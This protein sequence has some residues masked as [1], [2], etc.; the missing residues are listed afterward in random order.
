ML[1]VFIFII[2]VIIPLSRILFN[3][4]IFLYNLKLKYPLTILL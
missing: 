3:L 1:I 4:E 2:I